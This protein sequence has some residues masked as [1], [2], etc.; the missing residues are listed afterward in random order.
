MSNRLEGIDAT[1]GIAM[2]AVYPSH[3]LYINYR[4]PTHA[5]FTHFVHFTKPTFML[6]TGLMIEYLYQNDKNNWGKI[7]AKFIDRVFLNNSWFFLN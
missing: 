7:S 2:I 3:F 4:Y 5:I 6:I 1:K